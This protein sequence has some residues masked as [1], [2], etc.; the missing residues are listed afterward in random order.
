MKGRSSFKDRKQLLFGKP[1]RDFVKIEEFE[2][3]VKDLGPQL[4]YK[5]VCIA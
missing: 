4:P 1:I 3:S 5:T 2:V